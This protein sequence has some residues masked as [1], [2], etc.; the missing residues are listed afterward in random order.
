MQRE[1]CWPSSA[2]QAWLEQ[3]NAHFN[4]VIVEHREQ[5]G[6]RGRGF[7]IIARKDLPSTTAEPT[8]MTVPSD[9][10]LTVEWVENQAGRDPQLHELLHVTAE[11]AATPRGAILLYLLLQL[12]RAASA[13]ASAS[14]SGGLGPAGL[15]ADYLRF[16]SPVTALPTWWSEE[17]RKALVGTSLESALN[18]KLDRLAREFSHLRTATQSIPW[19]ARQWWGADGGSQLESDHLLLLDSWYRS[20]AF[21]LST[22][23]VAMIAGLDMVNHASGPAGNAYFRRDGDGDDRRA[24]L[25]LLPGKTVAAGDEITISYGDGKSAAEMLFS[26]G[27]IESGVVSTSALAL[28]LTVPADDPLGPAKDAASTTAPAVHISRCQDEEDPAKTPTTTTKS[29]STTWRSGFVWLICVN[30]EDGLRFDSTD[31]DDDAAADRA[32]RLRTF[33][34][35]QEISDD[36]A[37]LESLLRQDPLWDLYHLRAVVFLQE[38]VQAQMHRLQ[39]CMIEER[40]RKEAE[41]DDA[42]KV[43]ARLRVLEMDLLDDCRRSLGFQSETLLATSPA[44]QQYLAS[45]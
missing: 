43:A 21:G 30:E 24:A 31:A 19:C 36:T 4:G 13:L 35:G 39:R 28:D 44:V 27:F 14:S 32:P 9:L 34:K 37:Q 29:T 26:Y 42:A 41:D 3:N 8:L 5:E 15:W 2:L 11:L 20:R 7:A 40:E 22:A 38:R 16:L 33:W 23:A 1:A 6:L 25:V 45:D 10:I 12:T 17:Q 18:A